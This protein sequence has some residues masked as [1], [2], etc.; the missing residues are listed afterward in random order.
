ML[1]ELLILLKHVKVLKLLRLVVEKLLF[2]LLELELIR[3]QN[4]IEF[5]WFLNINKIKEGS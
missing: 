4:V 3:Q 5:G 2:E 1:V